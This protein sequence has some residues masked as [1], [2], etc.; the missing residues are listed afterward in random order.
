M[1]NITGGSQTVYLVYAI[2]AEDGTLIALDYKNETVAAGEIKTVSTENA[3]TD[4]EAKTARAFVW[5]GFVNVKP[6]GESTPFTLE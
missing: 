4:S 6:L 2:Y 3:L 5:D 1:R